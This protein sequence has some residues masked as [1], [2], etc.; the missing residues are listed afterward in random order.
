MLYKHNVS[1]LSPEKHS[2]KS[3]S[4][5]RARSIPFLACS[6]VRRVLIS[7]LTACTK[8]FVRT[9]DL[10]HVQ[11]VQCKELWQHVQDILQGLRP[12]KDGDGMK[13]SGL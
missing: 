1:L 5:L 7:L 2:R 10:N 11:R 8:S 13:L 6:S 4:S 9:H 3:C 12:D